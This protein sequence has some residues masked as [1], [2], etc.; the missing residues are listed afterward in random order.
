MVS[1]IVLKLVLIVPVEVDVIVVSS[2]LVV[3]M[4]SELEDSIELIKSIEFKDSGMLNDKL[5]VT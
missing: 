3:V 2:T 1:P 5:E 4:A